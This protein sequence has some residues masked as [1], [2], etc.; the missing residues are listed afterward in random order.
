MS[1]D[2]A[3]LP[4]ERQVAVRLRC[5]CC[6]HVGQYSAE[7]VIRNLSPRFETVKPREKAGEDNR[8]VV[9]VT[10]ED[11]TTIGVRCDRFGCTAAL[12]HRGEIR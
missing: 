7:D 1:I 3:E 8:K 2:E 4:K 12:C 6:N 11:G 9:C 5:P 10:I